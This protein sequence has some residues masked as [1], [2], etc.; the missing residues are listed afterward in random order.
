MF[1]RS[2]L[3]CCVLAV[4]L[5][6]GARGDFVLWDDD[7]IT[8]DSYHHEGNLYDSS[9]AF[10]VPGG[11]VSYLYAHDSSTVDM[12]GGYRAGY[13]ATTVIKRSD[14]GMDFMPGGIG[15]DISVTLNIEAI[16][17]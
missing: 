5:T 11:E 1:S 15:D 6:P 4:A 10:I 13:K 3:M 16:K 2:V 7:E 17:Q 12:S 9:R 14:F 8:V